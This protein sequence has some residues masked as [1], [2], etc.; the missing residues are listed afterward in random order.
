MTDEQHKQLMD[1]LEAIERQIKGGNWPFRPALPQPAY[2]PFFEPY[3]DHTGQ[4]LP[5]MPQVTD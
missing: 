5:R 1:K 4:P 3:R 2:E